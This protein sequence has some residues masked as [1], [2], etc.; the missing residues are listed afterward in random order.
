V[1]P[2]TQTIE[3]DCSEV[4]KHLSSYME[5]DLTLEKRHQ[6]EH[7]LRACRRCTAV[8][9]GTKNVVQLLGDKKAIDLPR[10]FS[11]RLYDRLVLQSSQQG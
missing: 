8:Y 10:G 2:T 6:L 7:H 5:G 4:W 3:I 11:E 1:P 9:D